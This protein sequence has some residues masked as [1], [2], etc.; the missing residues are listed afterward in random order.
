M[1]VLTRAATTGT[2]REAPPATGLPT[3]DLL[4][5]TPRSPER[6]LLLRAG[7]YAVYRAAGRRGEVGVEEPVPAPDEMLP[8][9]SA[10]AA[11]VLRR[12][13]AAQRTE[14]LREALDRL[15]LARLRVPHA[16]LPLALDVQ[17]TELR[18]A[19]A[20][21]LGERGPWLATQNPDWGWAV[22]TRGS[23]DDETVWEEGAL[24]ERVST[25]RHVR[26]RDPALGL[27]LVEDVWKSEKADARVAMVTALG[28]GLSPGDEPFLERAL[29]DRSGR[30]RGAAATLLARIPD[31][32]YAARAATRAD[33]VLAGYE[34]PAGDLRGVAAGLS[35]R[36]HAGRLAV[37]PPEHPDEGWQRDLPGDGPERGVGQKAWWI[38]RALSVVPPAHW[39]EHFGVAPSELIAAARGDWEMALLAGWCRASALHRDSSWAAPLWRACYRLEH[40]LEGWQTW[41]FALPLANMLPQSDLASA[42]GRL[43]K[44][45]EMSFR[46]SSTLQAVSDPWQPELSEAF[47][48]GLRGRIS[49]IC[50]HG[51]AQEEEP[52]VTALVHASVSLAPE[53]LIRATG[54]RESLERCPGLPEHAL[55]RWVPELEKFE[56]TLELRRR[57][58]EEV[59]L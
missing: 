32:D 54:F 51:P 10:K 48:E 9:C 40:D 44:N 38:S 3:D 37:E 53:C 26:D 21:V 55:R 28:T 46:L 22:T 41:Q 30:V 56:E 17:R 29:D 8:A 35:R 14:I 4:G 45:G 11:E 58:V 5:S 12:L 49:G 20:A 36:G 42:I 19:V 7:M 16:L 33:S 1:D 2:S 27:A 52:W 15:R 50:Q 59:P 18:S 25:L 31:S 57:L 6:N 47:L 43:P 24:G 39:E 34:P 23:G 13:L